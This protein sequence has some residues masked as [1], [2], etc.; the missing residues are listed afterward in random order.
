[1]RGNIFKCKYILIYAP[2]LASITGY[3]QSHTENTN[4]GQTKE[5]DE[6]SFVLVHHHAN[7]SVLSTFIDAIVFPLI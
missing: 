2:A 3:F 4:G 6:R 5:A 7:D 1:M